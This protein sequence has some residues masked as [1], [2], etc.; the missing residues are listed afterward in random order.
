ML[1]RFV[2]KR[3]YEF[4]STD[5]V[6]DKYVIENY[7][8]LSGGGYAVMRKHKQMF[9]VK[10]LFFKKKVWYTTKIDHMTFT[11]ETAQDLL[12]FELKDFGVGKELADTLPLYGELNPNDFVPVT[13]DTRFVTK[14]L[15]YARPYENKDLKII[16]IE[17]VDADG[18]KITHIN[19][20]TVTEEVLDRL[21]IIYRNTQMYKE[22]ELDEKIS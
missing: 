11:E 14:E 5:E 21:N 7:L 1:K 8:D 4:I 20:I 18:V 9:V 2:E 17:Y 19:S 3:L 12:G 15:I 16:K 6:S 22:E 13:L 10:L